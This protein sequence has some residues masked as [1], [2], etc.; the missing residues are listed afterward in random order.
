MHSAGL[1]DEAAV[2]GWLKDAESDPLPELRLAV[3]EWQD[4]RVSRNPPDSE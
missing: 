1:R 3:E 2:T 4:G